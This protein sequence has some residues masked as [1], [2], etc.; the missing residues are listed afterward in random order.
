MILHENSHRSR[1]W[2][3][4]EAK[5]KNRNVHRLLGMKLHLGSWATAAI[6]RG[7]EELGAP[8]VYVWLNLCCMK[9]W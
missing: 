1:P 4:S 3:S 6:P 8:L 9:V 7:G 2:F 5:W